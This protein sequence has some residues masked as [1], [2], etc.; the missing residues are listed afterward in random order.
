MKIKPLFVTDYSGTR[1]E[2]LIPPGLVDECA[3]E[4]ISK[5]ITDLC[6]KSSCCS[7]SLSSPPESLSVEQRRVVQKL[8]KPS[9]QEEIN[10][11]LTSHIYCLFKKVTSRDENQKENNQKIDE[12][13]CFQ[14]METF[15]I[16]EVQKIWL[17]VDAQRNAEVEKVLRE[18]DDLRSECSALWQRLSTKS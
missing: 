18:T 4:L 6:R 14:K 12:P 7:F 10:N 13:E 1:H 17:V 11:E 16:E 5:K 3:N 9:I 2:L 15:L 8:H